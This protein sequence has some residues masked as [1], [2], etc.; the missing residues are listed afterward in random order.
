MFAAGDETLG[1][2]EVRLLGEADDAVNLVT[3]RRRQSLTL[4]HVAEP[5]VSKSRID[6]QRD[7]RAASGH[8]GRGRQ[9]GAKAIRI[10]DQVVGMNG[11]HDSAWLH[12]PGQNRAQSDSRCRA[13]RHR[14][15]DDMVG[16]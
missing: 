15:A 9:S 14:L 3:I 6:A 16:R 13:A 11:G 10:E 2:W 8:F 7:E 5:G 1:R 4:L 12:M